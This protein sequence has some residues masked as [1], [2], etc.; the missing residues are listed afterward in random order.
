MSI[1][2]THALNCCIEFRGSSIGRQVNVLG[3]SCINLLGTSLGRQLKTLSVCI[4]K[5]PQDFRSWHFQDD[6]IGSLENI[7][8]TL[9]GDVFYSILNLLCIF[10]VLMPD[11]FHVFS[12]SSQR[13]IYSY[14]YTYFCLITLKALSPS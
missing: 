13:S 6:S 11:I 5:C 12:N 9:E 1:S 2:D 10:I 3:T 8:G 7:L 4:F 14:R